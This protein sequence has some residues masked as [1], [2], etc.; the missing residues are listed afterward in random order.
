MGRSGT[1]VAREASD[2]VLADDNFVSIAAAVEEG[3][4]TFDNVRKVTFFL[5]ST[6]AATIIAILSACG[7][8][9][10]LLMLPAQLLW[11][12]L[13][14]NGLQDVALAFEPGEKDVLRRRPAAASEGILSR[15]CGSGR[16]RR[17]VMA[18]GTL[19]MFRW[20]LDRTDSLD[21][22]RPSR[23]RRW[24]CHGRS[25]S[26][27]PARSDVGVPGT[28]DVRKDG[29][30][31]ATVNRPGACFGEMSILLGGT[32]TASVVADTACRFRLL[33]QADAALHQQPELVHGIA[34]MLAE[35]LQLV[36]AFLADLKRQ[37]GDAEGNLAM[38]DSVLDALLRHAPGSAEPGSE[39]E[40]D[41]L[42]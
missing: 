38:V 42:Y 31:V 30:R 27:T 4:V 15:C 18:A 21:R 23:S 20:E 28:V 8:G 24:S 16:A 6:G 13:V 3:R 10:P 19:I 5:V 14:T 22:R 32:H 11:L 41:P 2:M 12:N 39:R 35:R 1:D 17:V 29:V 37:Y 34:T 33:E 9:W 40:P 25:T 7:L 36:T 26:A